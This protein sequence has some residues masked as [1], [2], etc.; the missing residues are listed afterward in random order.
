MDQI[1]CTNIIEGQL[2]VKKAVKGHEK[3]SYII[4]NRIASADNNDNDFG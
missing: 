4:L 3:A 2:C 1:G